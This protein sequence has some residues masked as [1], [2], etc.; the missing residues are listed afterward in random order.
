[1]KLFISYSRDDKQWVYEF[2]R[3]LSN[4]RARHDVWLDQ[5]LHVSQKWWDEILNRIEWC[6]ATIVFLTP[7]YVNSPFCMAELEYALALNKPIMPLRMKECEL[8]DVLKD[9]QYLDIEAQE[10]NEILIEIASSLGDIR[11]ELG[12]YPSPAVK[13]TRPRVPTPKEDMPSDPFE[14]FAAVH[15]AAEQDDL[16]RAEKLAQRLKEIDPEGFGLEIDAYLNE[17]RLGKAGINAYLK[18]VAYVETGQMNEARLAWKVYTRQYGKLNY[19]PK[20]YATTLG[21]IL[22]VKNPESPPRILQPNWAMQHFPAQKSEP[23]PKQSSET[24]FG[25][26]MTDDKSVEMVYVPAGTFLMGSSDDDKYGQSSEKPQHKVVISHPFWL[27]L[28]PVTNAAYARFIKAGAY[29]I[30]TFWT[31]EGWQWVQLNKQTRPENYDG[32]TADEQPRIGVTWYEA[33]A[34]CRWRGGRLPTEAEWEWAARGEKSLIYPWGNTF[35]RDK[36]V[37]NGNSI[38]K[39]VNV[40]SKPAGASWVGALD[41]SG[42]VEEWTN[43]LSQPYPYQENDGREGQTTGAGKRVLRGGAWTA[44]SSTFLRSAHRWGLAPTEQGN[45]LGFRCVRPVMS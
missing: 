32:F 12:N 45:Y 29:Q 17:K 2:A 31:P 16:A 4:M 42:N 18:I 19:D 26:R 38:D 27:D 1:M 34:Y 40:G 22:A 6:E 9:I 25:R 5:D 35:D 8:P 33:D 3:R 30:Q 14:L 43:S 15:Q 10:M 13:P 11:A 28:T 36:V 20:G 37:W 23:T 44:T 24:T 7:R 39:S 41:M 21:E